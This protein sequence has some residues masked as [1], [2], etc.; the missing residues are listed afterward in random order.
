MYII[1]SG[2]FDDV[3]A[4][5]EVNE[6]DVVSLSSL[7]SGITQSKRDNPKYMCNVRDFRSEQ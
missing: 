6:D 1:I 7:S 4:E 3:P 5:I 2:I